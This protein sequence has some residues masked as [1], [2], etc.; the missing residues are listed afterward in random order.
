[1][2]AEFSV[3]LAQRLAKYVGRG[4]RPMGQIGLHGLI[5]LFETGIDEFGAIPGDLSQVACGHWVQ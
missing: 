4:D 3:P 2:N 1:V 5:V